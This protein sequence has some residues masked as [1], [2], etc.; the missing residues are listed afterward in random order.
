MI[1]RRYHPPAD[2][3]E[4]LDQAADEQPTNAP[5]ATKPAGR[6]AAPS[7]AKKTDGG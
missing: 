1:L 5:P 7:K 4:Q 2:D 6:S 3:D